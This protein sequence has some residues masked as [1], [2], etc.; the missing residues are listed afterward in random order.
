[1][2][3]RWQQAHASSARL[4]VS[5]TAMLVFAKT[6]PTA[7]KGTTKSRVIVE[8]AANKV[9]L[10]PTERTV[11]IKSRTIEHSVHVFKVPIAVEVDGV[12]CI[13]GLETMLQGT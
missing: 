6:E 3:Q 4:F 12:G 13:N 8:R 5:G 7:P 2:G 11:D 9:V 1:M 10:T